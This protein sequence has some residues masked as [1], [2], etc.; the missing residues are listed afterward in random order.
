MWEDLTANDR[1][2]GRKQSKHERRITVSED[3][4][5]NKPEADYVKQQD[6]GDEVEAHGVKPGV[7]PAAERAATEEGPDVEAHGVKPGVK[8]AAELAATEEGP[9]VEAHSFK[10][11]VKPK[12]TP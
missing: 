2:V 12:A 7:K 8:P 6:D 11:G 1:L 3:R 5:W 9:D 4:D 10:P